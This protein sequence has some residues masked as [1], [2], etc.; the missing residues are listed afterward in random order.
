M[1]VSK[2]SSARKQFRARIAAKRCVRVLSDIVKI[3]IDPSI[4]HGGGSACLYLAPVSCWWQ[5]RQEICIQRHERRAHPR[6]QA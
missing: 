1:L 3:E 5:V 4:D 2:N 6:R